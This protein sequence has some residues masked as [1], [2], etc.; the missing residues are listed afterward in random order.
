MIWDFFDS[1]HNA[2]IFVRNALNC[3]SY[4][5]IVFLCVPDLKILHQPKHQN[6]ATRTKEKAVIGH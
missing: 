2:K 6:E 5:H 1:F 4:Y 3:D